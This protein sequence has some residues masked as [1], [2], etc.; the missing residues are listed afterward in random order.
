LG[1]LRSVYYP[2]YCVIA[3]HVKNKLHLNVCKGQGAR[4]KSWH[5]TPDGSYLR[6]SGSN[7][8]IGTNSSNLFVGD[9]A[10]LVELNRSR[11]EQK[12]IMYPVQKAN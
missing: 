1:R 5:L 4:T 10:S 6:D 11:N 9:I 8:V 3:N 12:I 2:E 7:M